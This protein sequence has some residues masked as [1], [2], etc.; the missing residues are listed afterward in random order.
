L[1]VRLLTC[2]PRPFEPDGSAQFAASTDTSATKP[3][4]QTDATSRETNVKRALIVGSQGQDGAYLT[5]LLHSKGYDVLGIGAGGAEGRAGVNP[6]MNIDIRDKAVVLGLLADAKPD[7]IYYLAAYH[8][9]AEGTPQDPYDLLQRSFE[10]NTLALNHFLYATVK[11]SVKSRLF[12]A[13]SSRVF[14]SPGTPVQDEQTPFNPVCPYGI[15]KASGAWLCRHYRQEIGAFCSVGI[16][17]NHESPRRAA[18]FVSRKIVKAAVAIRNGIQSQLVL[19]NLDARVDWGYAP[20]YV[21]AMW[22][23]LQSDLADDFV[24]ASGTLHSVRDFARTAFAAVD[25]DWNRYVTENTQVLSSGRPQVTLC[26]DNRKLQRTTG[27]RPQVSFEQMVRIMVQAEIEQAPGAVQS[28]GNA[29]E[30]N[31]ASR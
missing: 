20:D 16:L 1:A 25:L 31:A 10:V 21:S 5:E 29:G 24:I 27:W 4:H 6:A 11:A 14:G 23:I 15:S 18:P 12:Y 30:D 13:A 3:R 7:E 9:S 26:G 2:L 22:A 28:E 19:G 17:Y 8:Q